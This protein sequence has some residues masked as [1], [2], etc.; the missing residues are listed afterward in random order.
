V[1]KI[2]SLFILALFLS[3][4]AFAQLTVGAY[5]QSFW[6]PYRMTVPEE[7]DT[8]HTT[9]VQTPWGGPDISAGINFDGYT[10]WGGIHLGVDVANGASNQSSNFFSAKGSGWVWVKPLNIVPIM[11]SFTIYLGNPYGEQLMGKIGGSNLA[12]Y[13]LNASWRMHNHRLEIQNPQYNIFTRFNPYPWGNADTGKQNLYWPRIAAAAFISWEPIENFFFG[14]YIA[15][16]QFDLDG[17]SKVGGVD[18]ATISSANGDQVDSD[19]INQDYYDV[20]EVYRKIQVGAGFNMPGIGFVRAQYIGIRNT[21]EF[22]FQVTALGDLVLD[23]GAKIPFEGTIEED[24]HTYKKRKDFQVSV[25]ATFRYYDFRLLARVD[26]AFAGSNSDKV[27]EVEENGLNLIAYIVPSYNLSAGT[28]GAD[29]GFQYEQKDFR[30]T[31]DSMMAGAALWFQRNLG[32]AT[33]KAAA[34]TRFPLSWNGAQ[35][36]FDLLFPIYLMVGF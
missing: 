26:T 16:E 5:T 9:A 12:T 32:S 31:E 3:V 18:I 35:Q 30:V 34:V 20:N 17:W 13:V 21:V 7:G 36:P 33:F 19:D 25:A 10:D 23:I 4:S 8:L 2:L 29:F 28:I 6:I 1:K 27:R 24:T 11:E 14:A 15:P 22:A